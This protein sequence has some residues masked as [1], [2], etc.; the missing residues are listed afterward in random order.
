MGFDSVSMGPFS[1]LVRKV[2]GHD[3]KAMEESGRVSISGRKTRFEVIRGLTEEGLVH[4][5]PS[6][7]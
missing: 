3:Q 6:A 5:I 2:E 1:S 4:F 7:Q